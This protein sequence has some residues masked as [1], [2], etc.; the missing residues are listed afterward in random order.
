MTKLPGVF[1]HNDSPVTMG[2]I[3]VDENMVPIDTTELEPQCETWD[4]FKV[5]VYSSGGFWHHIPLIGDKADFYLTIP[6]NKE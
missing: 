5:T 2:N 3:H 1:W 6:A 4:E